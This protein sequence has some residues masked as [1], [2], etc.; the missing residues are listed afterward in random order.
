MHNALDLI[1]HAER[2]KWGGQT[3][4]EG[5]EKVRREREERKTKVGV[6]ID[7]FLLLSHLSNSLEAEDTCRFYHEGENTS[8]R[9]RAHRRTRSHAPPLCSGSGLPVPTK[10]TQAQR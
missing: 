10:C 3:E 2:K 8:I 6:G 7:L 4:R 9:D 5:R 1:V